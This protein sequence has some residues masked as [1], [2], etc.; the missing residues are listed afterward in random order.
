MANYRNMNVKYANKLRER[1][2][3]KI[4][5]KGLLVSE[6]AERANIDS[7]KFRHYYN[8]RNDINSGDLIAVLIALGY[9][10]EL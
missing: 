6:I 2:I 10:I 5:E 9:N 4:N 8:G 3:D 1:I 7:G